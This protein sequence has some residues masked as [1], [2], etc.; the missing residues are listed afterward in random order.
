M[1]SFETVETP[2]TRLLGIKYPIF[3]AGMAKAAGPELAAAVTNSGG[4]GVIGGNR[5]SPRLLSILIKKLKANLNEENGA[6]GIDL[7]IPKIGG[8]ARKTNYDYNKGKLDELLDV[9]INAG[10]CKLFVCAVGACSRSVAQKMHKH[11]I[12]VMNMVGHPKHVPKCLKNGVDIICAQG[13]EAGGHTG[14]IPTSIL[15]PKCVD[16][17]QGYKMALYPN[18]NVQVVGA[19]GIYNGRGIAMCLSF[20]CAGVW[21]GTRFVASV[22]SGATPKHKQAIVD[23]KWENAQTTLVYTGRPLR[24]LKNDYALK[25]ETERK[26]EMNELLSKGIIPVDLNK[27]NRNKEV[28]RRFLSGTV[29]GNIDDIKP[30]KEIVDDMMKECI[31]VLKLNANRIKT[32]SKL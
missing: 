3:L 15:L 6:Y 20:G 10:G 9:I 22:E 23:A 13:S 28:L 1:S 18:I 29:A 24:V 8:S 25:W 27:K 16:L 17:V 32:L 4:I 2:L 14:V 7:L 19:G 26:E 21:V 30:A 12:L 5:L 31:A 11:G